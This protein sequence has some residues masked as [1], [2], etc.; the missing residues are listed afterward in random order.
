MDGRPSN[1]A[2]Q[3][4]TRIQ[5]AE[6]VNPSGPPPPDAKRGF[7]FIMVL[8]SLCIS[9]FLSALELTSVPVALPTITD[10][11]HGTDFVWVTSAYALAATSLIPAMGGLAEIFGRKFS[12]LLSLAL[13]AVGSAVCGAAHNMNMLIAGR[14][15]QGAG[16]GG[17]QALSMIILSDLVSLK[18]RGTYNGLL[19]LV[20]SVATAIGPLIGGAFAKSG[21][22]RW[23]FY[24]NLPLTGVVAF[25]VVTCLKLK[26]PRST[27]RE[28]MG[29]IDWIGNIIITGSASS[30][31]LGLTTGGVTHPWTSAQTLVPLIIGF[32]GMF[33]FA[34]YEFNI[35]KEPIMPFL[36][37]SN[38]TSISGYMQTFLVPIVVLSVL[39]WEPTYYQACFDAS[40]IRAGVLL[41]PVSASIGFFIIISGASVA[42]TKIYRPQLWFGWITLIISAGVI[43]TLKWDTPIPKAI[44]LPFLIAI[45]GGIVFPNALFPVLAPLPVSENA[46]ALALFSFFRSFASVW[47]ITIGS[48]ILNNQLG[49][50]LSPE[51]L[52]NFPGGASGVFSS[53]PIIAM[54]PT[55]AQ[56]QVKVAFAE[57]TSVIWE[58]MAGIAGLGFLISLIMK[59]LPLHTGVDD[60]WGVEEQEKAKQAALE[61]EKEAVVVSST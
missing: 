48:T 2:S 27:F 33:C 23:L 3:S 13:F 15:V 29:R 31:V 17:I 30:A 5:S 4:T 34:I 59:G 61:A 52:S 47:C 56:I 28:K 44:G 57:A 19:G 25:I 51:I 38:R 49:K 54:L 21:N 41:L 37:V 58:T 55:E 11:L 46:H 14:A 1:S 22:W 43:S 6:N 16:G 9:L 45:G 8:V 12:T 26:T 36:L 20:W 10:Q 18:E 39:F 35:P 24:L 50:K 42:I 7:F 32:V 40:P 60:R 53:I